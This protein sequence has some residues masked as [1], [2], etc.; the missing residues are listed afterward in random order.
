MIAVLVHNRGVYAVIMAGGGGTRLWPLS[1]SRRP[2]PFL[3]LLDGGRYLLQATASRLAPLIE[4]DDIYVVT[5]A[6][7]ADLVREVAPEIPAAN[8]IGEPMGRNT[9]AAV[10][11]MAHAI[12]RPSDEVMVV[13]PADAAIRDEEAFRAALSTAAARAREGDMVTLGIEPTEPAIG[14]GYVIAGGSPRRYAGRDTFRVERFEEKPSPGR[15]EELI[16]S[17]AAYWNAGIFVWQRSAVVAGLERYAPDISDPIRDWISGQGPAAQAGWPGPAMAD[18]YGGIRATSIDYALLEPASLEGRV[19]VVPASVGWSDLGS[20]SALRDH[21][22]GDG[23]PVISEQAPARV[24]DVD[25]RDVF[26]HAAGGRLVAVVGLDDVVIVDT[27]DAL[28]VS[29]AE[30]AQDVKK[31][32]DRLKD[33]GRD[34][35]L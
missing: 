9:A 33:E 18:T 6:R 14:Y 35:L 24:I 31:V 10:A 13:L 8:I 27:P 1:R 25:G 29:S 11:L 23:V 19:A 22:G 21:R 20:W 15:A 2:K 7:Y 28:L 16:A 17:R 26:V 5:D 30:A 34:D 4:P 32:V 12:D 3:P